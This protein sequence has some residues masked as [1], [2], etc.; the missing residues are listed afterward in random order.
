M[1]MDNQQRIQLQKM[2]KDNNVEDHTNDIRN[3]KHSE[4]I[5]QEVTIIEQTKKEMKTNDYKTL[6][7][8]LQ[9]K[10]FFLFK[11]YTLIYTKL[12]KNNMNIDILYRLLDVLKTIEDG[13]SN[14]H[15]ASYEIGMLLKQ[16][17]ID[18]KIDE[19]SNTFRSS[20][21]LTFVEYMKNKSKYDSK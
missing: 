19:P 9:S 10:C 21:K 3:L 11:E 1:Y 17:Y 5:R 6:D 13:T 18:K 2:I 8:V 14:Q 4:K 12:L 20:K 15:E 16:I 7:N